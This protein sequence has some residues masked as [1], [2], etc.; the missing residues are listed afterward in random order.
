MSQD[1]LA[2]AAR[3]GEVAGDLQR[4]RGKQRWHDDLQAKALGEHAHQP[5]VSAIQVNA[6]LVPVSSKLGLQAAQEPNGVL[7]T[8]KLERPAGGRVFYR[9]YRT[10]KSGSSNCKVV[11]HGLPDQCGPGLDDLVCR[12][13]ASAPDNCLLSF[14]AQSLGATHQ[15]AWL[16]RPE[17]GTWIYRVALSANWLNDPQFG[18]AYVFSRPVTVSTR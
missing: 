17:P 3:P 12:V 1:Y 5:D 9:V 11:G 2:I 8:W 18:D 14:A 4:G 7:L 6:T 13:G 10:P 16:D 15:G